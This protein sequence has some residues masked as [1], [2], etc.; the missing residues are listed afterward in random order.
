MAGNELR[1]FFR[2]PE[3]TPPFFFL[4]QPQNYF[5]IKRIKTGIPPGIDLNVE[6]I[7]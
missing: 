5:L 1:N 4:A 6:I 3:G 2:Q 7:M